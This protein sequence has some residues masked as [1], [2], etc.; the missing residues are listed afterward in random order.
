[1][2]GMQ[3][4]H[5]TGE[6]NDLTFHS[7]DPVECATIT[8]QNWWRDM[9]ATKMDGSSSSGSSSSRDSREGKTVLCW[10]VPIRPCYPPFNL[11]C[12]CISLA[13]IPK[14]YHLTPTGRR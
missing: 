14:I 7:D 10:L 4:S 12:F 11:A 9:L 3:I 1:M 8:L 6:T 13:V 5:L 2:T